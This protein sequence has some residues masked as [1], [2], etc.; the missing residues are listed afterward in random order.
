MKRASIWEQSRCSSSI[1]TGMGVEKRLKVH[2]HF[3]KT[4]GKKLHIRN[5]FSTHSCDKIQFDPEYRVEVSHDRTST[6]EW[7]GRSFWAGVGSKEWPGPHRSVPQSPIQLGHSFIGGS[8]GVKMVKNGKMTIFKKKFKI[9]LWYPLATSSMGWLGSGDLNVG[10][11]VKSDEGSPMG[12]PK[13]GK[14]G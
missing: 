6:S 3:C 10:I 11:W 2:F 12:A 14:M 8:P 9:C 7:T 13:M 5:L 4:R 1:R